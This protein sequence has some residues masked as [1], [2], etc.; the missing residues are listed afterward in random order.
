MR[1][2]R[3][4]V[5][6][7]VMLFSLVGCNDSADDPGNGG[8][9]DDV[10]VDAASDTQ[11]GDDTEAVEGSADMSVPTCNSRMSDC[12][13]GRWCN[14]SSGECASCPIE[15]LSC[16]DFEAGESSID[17]D[18]SRVSVKLAWGS[19]H[20]ES[21]SFD[22]EE[23]RAGTGAGWGEL[24]AE[25]KSVEGPTTA[26]V[27]FEPTGSGDSR[28]NGVTVTDVCG[29]SHELSITA[30]WQAEGDVTDELSCGPMTGGGG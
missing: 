9:A 25:N 5:V 16:D 3:L 14:T 6:A 27:N 4:A 19:V 12:P 11:P 29:D 21:I 22:A 1:W 17:P 28:L 13:S 30:R 8:S 23:E 24:Q 7:L 18:A 2:F 26:T 20:M 10:A 15:T